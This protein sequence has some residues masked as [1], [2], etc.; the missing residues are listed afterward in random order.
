MSFP[1]GGTYHVPHG[2]S[3][4][5]LFGKILEL[6]NEY[7]PNGELGKFKE[8]VARCLGCTKD[9]ALRTL[10]VTLE[11]VLPLKPLHELYVYLLELP[12]P[13]IG[14]GKSAASDHQ[15]LPS[16]EHRTERARI[17]RVLLISVSVSP[18]QGGGPPRSPPC[19]F[20]EGM[21]AAHRQTLVKV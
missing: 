2:E 6:Y 17:P 4:Y 3:N 14:R 10:N 18:E 21:F 5:A 19:F 20:L 1:L 9:D 12:P 16:V 8:I 15:L 13:R 7:E 11:K